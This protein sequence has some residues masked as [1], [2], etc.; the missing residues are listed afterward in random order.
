MKNSIYTAPSRL[1]YNIAMAT[2]KN[3]TS[4][5]TKLLTTFFTLKH[6]QVPCSKL[7]LK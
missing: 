3:N 7:P 1:I 4:Y 2:I 6:K 5:N